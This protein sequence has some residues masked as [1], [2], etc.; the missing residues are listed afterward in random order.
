MSEVTSPASDAAAVEQASMALFELT[1]KALS[2]SSQLSVLQLRTLLAVEQHGPLRLADLANLLDLSRPS[3]SRLIGRLADDGFVLRSTPNHDRREIQ[4]AVSA[5]GRRLL[6]SL[7]S[8]RQREISTVLDTMP[9]AGR[10]ALIRGLSA[11]AAAA[12][13]TPPDHR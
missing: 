9:S 1:L 7:R 6:D 11:F 8:R 3:A 13:A 12:S 5:K 10:N 4:L 2:A